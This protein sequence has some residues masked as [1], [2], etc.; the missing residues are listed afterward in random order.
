M[1]KWTSG[2][3]A[4]AGFAS[5]ATAGAPSEVVQLRQRIDPERPP[6]VSPAPLTINPIPMIVAGDPNGSPPDSPAAR[7][8]PNTASSPFRGVCSLFIGGGFLCTG[9]PISPRHILTA[10]HCFDTS[11]SDGTNDHGTNVQVTFNTASNQDTVISSVGI[12][13]VDLHPDFTGF[14]NPTI[15]D[16][17]AI[18]TLTNPLPADIP[19]YPVFIGPVAGGQLI[20][21]IGYGTTGDGV[22]GFINGSASLVTK[23]TGQNRAD[24]F[25]SDD[26]GG[27]AIELFEFDFDGPSASSNCDEF[28]PG[29]TLGND[30]ETAL[31]GGDS[32]GPSLISTAEGAT[33]DDLRLWGVNTFGGGCSNFIGPPLFGSTGGGVVASGYFSWLIDFVPPSPFS[34]EIPANGATGQPTDVTLEWSRADFATSYNLTIA[35]NSS[36]SNV[37]LQE[38]GLTELQF[39]VPPGT[40]DGG[41]EFFWTV[42]AVNN[43]GMTDPDPLLFFSFTTGMTADLNGD[44]KVDGNDL[45][46][47][48]LSWGSA[49]SQSGA[50]LDDSGLVDGADLGLLLLAWTG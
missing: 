16:D 22:N 1:K 36:L 47:L 12:Q 10:A 17:L 24:S 8:D 6:V 23:R 41:T 46:L 38:T 40:L 2:M 25:A 20:T 13:S 21:A 31:G 4:A 48:L 5:A 19:I 30:I 18:V 32:G 49:G 28:G 45:G 14:A 9:T 37:V 29:L 15:N 44:G 50:D 34:L 39:D 42:E 26:E 27:A 33:A 11:G 43:N 35:A 7:I 3:L